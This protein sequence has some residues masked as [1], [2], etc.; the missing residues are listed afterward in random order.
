MLEVID[1][2]TLQRET[3]SVGE[4][5]ALLR[6]HNKITQVAF[7]EEIKAGL[8][9]VSKVESGKGE[10]TEIQVKAA[11]I[12]F[13][14]VG[15]PL[16]ER[17]RVVFIERLYRWRDAIR[18]RDMDEARKIYKEM[19]NIDNLEPCD[20]DMVMLCKI[21]EAYMLMVEN[22]LAAAGK[23]LNSAASKLERMNNENQY[24]YY[25]NKGYF[26]YLQGHHEDSLVFY[27]K[28]EKLLSSNEELLPE[29]DAIL[30]YNIG[31]CYSYIQIPYMAIHYF[32]KARQIYPENRKNS[33]YQYLNFNLALNYIKVNQPNEAEK[34]LNKCTVRAEGAKDDFMIGLSLYGFG[35]MH[36]NAEN[37]TIAIRYFEQAIDYLPNETNGYFSAFYHMIF[38]MIKARLFSKAR[39]ELEIAQ[40]ECKNN[41]LWATYF[42]SLEHFFSISKRMS[43]VN[44]IA[45]DYIENIAI[46]YFR[47]NHDHFIALEYCALLEQHYEKIRRTT[48]P[49][50]IKAM[51]IDIQEHVFF[52]KKR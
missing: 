46:P 14:I 9:R 12:L 27:Q 20:F 3:L 37:W 47:K 16:S 35:H 25:M 33:W 39:D 51:I 1:L 17:E 49:I 7:A 24:H 23:I 40:A 29:D 36:K 48:T 31:L 10:Y 44:Y 4:K 15:L 43:I 2:S 28:A 13:K 41:E 52:Q 45:S 38:C 11:K 5:I 30:Y 6:I 21:F 26:D 34:L 22:D 8:D 42:Q 50:N 19:A 32:L 18:A